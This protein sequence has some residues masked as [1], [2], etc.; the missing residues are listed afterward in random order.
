VPIFGNAR[1]EVN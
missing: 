1:N